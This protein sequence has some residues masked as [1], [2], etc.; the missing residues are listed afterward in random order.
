MTTRP[1]CLSKT[2]GNSAEDFYEGGERKHQHPG[3]GRQLIT[4]YPL[5]MVKI[6]YVPMRNNYRPNRALVLPCLVCFSSVLTLARVSWIKPFALPFEL[7]LPLFGLLLMSLDYLSALPCW[8]LFAYR[9]HTLALGLFLCLAC[10][11][12]VCHCLTLPVY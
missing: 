1:R 2:V 11:I 8:I 9:R 3:F 5:Y 6:T 4:N 7:C 10:T 12:P